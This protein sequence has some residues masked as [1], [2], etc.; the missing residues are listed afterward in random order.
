[1]S[2]RFVGNGDNSKSLALV[3]LE[4]EKDCHFWKQLTIIV[5]LASRYR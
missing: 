1:M 5:Y 4:K 2:E 3:V